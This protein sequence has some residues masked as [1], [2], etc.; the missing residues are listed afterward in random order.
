MEGETLH[1]LKKT[2]FKITI[3]SQQR[4]ARVERLLRCK[5]INSNPSPELFKIIKV[6][7]LVFFNIVLSILSGPLDNH[8]LSLFFESIIVSLSSNLATYFF[9]KMIKLLNALFSA[10][11]HDPW[12]GKIKN[13]SSDKSHGKVAANSLIHSPLVTKIKATFE[14]KRCNK[15]LKPPAT[16][17]IAINKQHESKNN[18]IWLSQG[19]CNFWNVCC[20]L[21]FLFWVF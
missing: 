2:L 13:V 10:P 18:W 15:S 17:D 16:K 7:K 5:R 14:I 19:L 8:I 11:V 6:F 3:S 12:N 21:Y 20:K 9:W 4:P 1:L